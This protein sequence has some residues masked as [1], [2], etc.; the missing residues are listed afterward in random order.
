MCAKIVPKRPPSLRSAYVRKTDAY[1][2]YDSLLNTGKSLLTSIT[3]NSK[4]KSFPSTTFVSSMNKTVQFCQN[5]LRKYAHNKIA[6][7]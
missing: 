1:K 5:I 6:N 4:K 3:I 7:A 2:N